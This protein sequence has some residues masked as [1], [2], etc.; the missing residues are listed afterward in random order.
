MAVKDTDEEMGQLVNTRRVPA[1][2]RSQNKSKTSST[3]GLAVGREFD[4]IR[5]CR[6]HTDAGILKGCREE[7]K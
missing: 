1:L 3:L 7:N 5:C 4:S 6:G 2:T